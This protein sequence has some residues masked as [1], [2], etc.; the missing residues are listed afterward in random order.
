MLLLKNTLKSDHTL[1]KKQ[2][3]LELLV[4]SFLS[5]RKEK[6]MGWEAPIRWRWVMADHC[7]SLQELL[8][9]LVS[10][11]PSPHSRQSCESQSLSTQSPHRNDQINTS[12]ETLTKAAEIIQT[13]REHSRWGKALHSKYMPLKVA[14][15]FNNYCKTGFAWSCSKEGGK[16]ACGHAVTTQVF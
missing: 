7:P 13:L 6:M 2:S 14:C 4:Y 16:A 3:A 1:A 12:Q 11:Q 15:Y 10:P 5:T 8:E 9:E